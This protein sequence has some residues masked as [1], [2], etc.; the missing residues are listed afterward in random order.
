MAYGPGMGLGSPSSDGPSNSNATVTGSASYVDIIMNAGTQSGV[1]PYVLA[2]MIIQEQGRD[3]TG[4][5]ISG[6]E[7]G[8]E[9]YYCLLYTSRCV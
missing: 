9:G 2:A 5:S 3:G 8:Y 4:G 6:T 7:P 1:N